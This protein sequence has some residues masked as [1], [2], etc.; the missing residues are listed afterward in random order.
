MFESHR[1]ASKSTRWKPSKKCRYCKVGCA[2]GKYD[3]RVPTICL[4][5]EQHF[6]AT[7]SAVPTNR[8]P[9]AELTP[10]SL[11]AAWSWH[12]PGAMRSTSRS[13]FF[14]TAEAIVSVR[15]HAVLSDVEEGSY[16]PRSG[17]IEASI[18]TPAPRGP[19]ACPC[20]DRPSDMS[21]WMAICQRPQPT[22]I[23][24]RHAPRPAAASWRVRALG[25][26]RA[27]C[28]KLLPTRP[29]GGAGDGGASPLPRWA[30][31]A[32]RIR[33]LAVHGNAAARLL[34]TLAG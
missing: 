30:R 2:A 22:M 10:S 18:N 11:A 1:A 24:M 6:A 15:R 5:S 8:L 16:L 29:P 32:Q 31:L 19:D 28:F 21:G 4:S 3:R 34:A 23:F 33:E 17:R 12:R 13:S 14:A 7:M 9:T 20:S 25:M 27:G 26:G